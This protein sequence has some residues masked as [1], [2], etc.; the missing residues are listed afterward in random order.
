METNVTTKGQMVIPS[1]LRRKYGIKVGTKIIV[2][3][4][5]K[6]IILIPVTEE[7]LQQI[8]GSLKGKN[9]LQS[10]INKREPS[11]EA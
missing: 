6:R 1:S 5:G 4:D 10:L 7:Y 8:Q 2:E 11:S 3:D 9:L